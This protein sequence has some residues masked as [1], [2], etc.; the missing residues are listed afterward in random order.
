MLSL[1]VLH[2]QA[3]VICEGHAPVTKSFPLLLR[4]DIISY[5]WFGQD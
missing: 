3:R 4:I 5:P 2:W 1:L